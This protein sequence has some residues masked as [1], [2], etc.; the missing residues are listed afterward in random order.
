MEEVFFAFALTLFA[1]L[2]TGIGSALAFFTKKT[3]TK[4]LSISLGFSA[5]VMIYVSMIEIFAEA[6]NLLS[7]ELGYRLGSWVTVGA[8]FAGMLII[9]FI[10]KLIPSAENPHEIYKVEELK[11][12]PSDIPKSNDK[13]LRTGLITALAITIHNFPEGLAI[14]S[15]THSDSYCYS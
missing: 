7:L 1:G 11:E 2:S 3:N 10:D 5:G 4:F 13:L 15:N 6:R 9:A 12:V 14:N 8:F